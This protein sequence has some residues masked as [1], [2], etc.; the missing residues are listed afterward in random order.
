MSSTSPKP[1]T[2]LEAS[3]GVPTNKIVQKSEEKAFYDNPCW[4]NAGMRGSI[5]ASSA[6]LLGISW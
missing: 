3:G 4:D 2:P 5:P 6:G 1:N